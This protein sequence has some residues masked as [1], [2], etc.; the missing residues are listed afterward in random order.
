MVVGTGAT[1]DDAVRDA[2][3]AATKLVAACC[4]LDEFNAMKL[5]GLAGQTLFCQHCCLTKSVR[6]AV[7][8]EY[9]PGPEI[10]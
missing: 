9:L 7:P 10:G 2:S 1:V 8:L 4:P 6:V 3:D 5:L